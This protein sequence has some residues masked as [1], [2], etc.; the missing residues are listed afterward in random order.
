MEKYLNEDALKYIETHSEEAVELLKT[1]GKIP[2]PSHYE[3]QRVDFV[4]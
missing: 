1:L 2:A 4:K 3:D